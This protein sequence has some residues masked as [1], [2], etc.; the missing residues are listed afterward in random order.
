[1]DTEFLIAIISDCHLFCLSIIMDTFHS[2]SSFLDCDQDERQQEGNQKRMQQLV[3]NQFSDTRHKDPR[4]KRHHELQPYAPSDRYGVPPMKQ[5]NKRQSTTPISGTRRPTNN[6]LNRNNFQVASRFEARAERP[7]DLSAQAD[8]SKR[9]VIKSDNPSGPIQT[10]TPPLIQART[11]PQRGGSKQTPAQHNVTNHHIA[12]RKAHAIS[13]RSNMATNS[14][15]LSKQQASTMKSNTLT[16]KQVAQTS[17]SIDEAKL[18]AQTGPPPSTE[19]LSCEADLSAFNISSSNVSES[20]QMGDSNNGN[21]RNDKGETEKLSRL[22][23]YFESLAQEAEEER[24]H[25]QEL[26]DNVLMKFN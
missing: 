5:S 8:K 19:E 7:Q 9:P 6:H 3:F 11:L 22:K 10:G 20:E 17:N 1:M 12:W 18:E 26:I 23:S 13:P 15:R 25:R 14:V 4:M 21:N 2:S 24:R 16:N